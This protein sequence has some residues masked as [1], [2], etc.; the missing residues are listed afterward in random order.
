LLASIVLG[1]LAVPVALIFVILTKTLK[2]LVEPLNSKPIIRGTLGGLLL[3]LLA[4][5]IP[6]TVGL[7]TTE[8]S[9]VTQQ[10]AE[11]G[12]ILLLVFALAKVLALSGA[13]S[14]GFIG[15]PIFPLLFVG[16][17]L[18]AAVHLIFPQVP[19]ALALGC[20]I[21]AVPA[22]ILPIPLSMAAI[23]IVIIGLSPTNALPV[24]VSALAAFSITHG[25]GMGGAQG[26][27]DSD[28]K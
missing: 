14:F 13:L 23:G 28:E 8:M 17:S 16:S 25:L 21:V 26:K 9:V 5:A 11:I 24:F 22:A 6:T 20:M 1:V 3:G 18:G 7:G 27:K 12:V 4:V 2:R 19:L 10:A 15:G